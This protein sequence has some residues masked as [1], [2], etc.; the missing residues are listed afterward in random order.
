MSFSDSHKDIVE[1]D[2]ISTGFLRCIGQGEC[3]CQQHASHS[4]EED[5]F[6][7]DLFDKHG[8]YTA[9]L[10]TLTKTAFVWFVVILAIVLVANDKTTGL[11]LLPSLPFFA[12]FLVYVQRNWAGLVVDWQLHRREQGQKNQQAKEEQERQREQLYS[13]SDMLQASSKEF[14]YMVQRILQRRGYKLVVVGKAGD[15]GVDLRGTGPNGEAVIVQCKRQVQIS[16][17]QP[18]VVRELIGSVN[19]E[20]A[21]VGILATT[22]FFGEQAQRAAA[23]ARVRIVLLD[24][25]DLTM[26]AG[27]SYQRLRL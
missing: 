17:I 20:G 21:D 23:K 11:L 16:R 10:I 12:W 2:Q 19:S 27:T 26:L 5:T 7:D 22:T 9:V 25:S 13:I 4:A 14:E 24:G 6:V 3:K 8:R 15:Q 18:N 1:P